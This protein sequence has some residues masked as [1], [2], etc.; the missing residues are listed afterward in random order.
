MI[1]IEF[2][3]FHVPG[4]GP[5]VDIGGPYE[6]LHSPQATHLSVSLLLSSVQNLQDQI[7]NFLSP[8]TLLFTVP[9]ASHTTASSCKK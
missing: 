8:V 2:Q 4:Y 7:F 6:Y 3:P 5:V 1:Y 9:H